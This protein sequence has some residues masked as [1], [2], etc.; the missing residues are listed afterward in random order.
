MYPGV[1]GI[2]ASDGCMHVLNLLALHTAVIECQLEVLHL[3]SL[4]QSF[5]GGKLLQHCRRHCQIQ[6]H[7]NT[8]GVSAS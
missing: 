4:F 7:P 6:A 1:Q 8:P 3:L 2:H 5:E